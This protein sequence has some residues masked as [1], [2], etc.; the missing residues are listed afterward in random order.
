V[1]HPIR[2][3]LYHRTNPLSRLTKPIE[4]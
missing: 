3:D 2:A 4:L 1:D